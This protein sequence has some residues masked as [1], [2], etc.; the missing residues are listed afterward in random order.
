AISDT[1]VGMTDEI[2]AHLFE[3]FFTTKGVD[4]GTGLGLATCY[5]IISQSGGDI[6]GYSEPNRGTTFKVYLPRLDAAASPAIDEPDSLPR[7]TES[8]LVVEDEA[9]VRGLATLCL[10]ECGYEVEE[11]R[12]A[13]EALS[14]IEKKPRFDLVITDVIMPQMSGKELYEQ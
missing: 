5:G 13:P 11:A 7:G 2:K 4:K 12:N 14:L 1:G 10:R 3:P 6:R 9:S 8:V